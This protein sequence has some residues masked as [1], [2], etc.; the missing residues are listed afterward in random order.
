MILEEVFHENFA[1]TVDVWKRRCSRTRPTSL[2]ALAADRMHAPKRQHLPRAGTHSPVDIT[3][4]HLGSFSCKHQPYEI[5]AFAFLPL[6][7]QFELSWQMGHVLFIDALRSGYRLAGRWVSA[8][9]RAPFPCTPGACA[10]ASRG[11]S[12]HL[13]TVAASRF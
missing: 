9:A 13:E 7:N 12:Q 11:S 3:M 4:A 2:P 1:L 10:G 6:S 5:Q 8:S